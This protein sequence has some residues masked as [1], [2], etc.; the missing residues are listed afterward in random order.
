MQT[1][2]IPRKTGTTNVATRGYNGSARSIRVKK[3]SDYGTYGNGGIFRARNFTQSDGKRRT[4]M[5]FHSGRGYK[6][7]LTRRTGG[8]IRTT[9]CAIEA[10]KDAI[11]EYGP[12]TTITVVDNLRPTVTPLPSITPAPI[13]PVTPEPVVPTII[14][15]S[16]SP[17]PKPP[18]PI[19]IPPKPN[20]LDCLY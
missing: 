10:I 15:G 18:P 7:F 19:I 11:K 13:N 6:T 17:S 1:V 20:C 5:G 2:T 4:G 9:S 8:C 12:L 16:P 14:P 3:D